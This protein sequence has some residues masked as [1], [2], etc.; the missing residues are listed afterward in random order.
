[1]LVLFPPC[2]PHAVTAIA[3]LY[4]MT[5]IKQTVTTDSL[6]QRGFFLIHSEKMDSVKYHFIVP[7]G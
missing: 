3:S 2:A 1:M 7:A 6:P 5:S 4:I